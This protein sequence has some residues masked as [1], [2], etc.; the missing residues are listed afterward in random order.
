MLLPIEALGYDSPPVSDDECDGGSTEE[1]LDALSKMHISPQRPPPPGGGGWAL[2]EHAALLDEA[3][4]TAQRV[5]RCL[6]AAEA[7]R[8]LAQELLEGAL[9]KGWPPEVTGH[10]L[11]ALD[12]QDGELDLCATP[13]RSGRPMT[14]PGPLPSPAAQARRTPGG[15][16]CPPAR[17]A[18]EGQRTPKSKRH[19]AS[20]YGAPPPDEDDS[21]VCAT[22][23]QG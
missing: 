23:W 11:E 15:S 13:A 14:P 8:A 21:D 9:A 6:W 10:L 17:A 20:S 7:Q 5:R 19:L 3:T 16:T 12:L 18:D 2:P 4:A 1:P 22:P